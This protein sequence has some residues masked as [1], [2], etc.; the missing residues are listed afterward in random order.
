MWGIQDFFRSPNQIYEPEKFKA[1]E[2]CV[3]NIIA[4]FSNFKLESQMED[5]ATPS[6]TLSSDLKSESHVYF[7]KFLTSANLTELQL[8]DPSFRRQILTEIL[9]LFQSGFGNFTRINFDDLS[10]D[11][12]KILYSHH[13]NIFVHQTAVF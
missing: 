3:T 6:S 1:F 10:N 13:K 5:S 9:F 8:S 4:T 12:K 7:P 2:G 11:L